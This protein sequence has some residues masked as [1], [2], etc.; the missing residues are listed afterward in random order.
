MK[1]ATYCEQSQSLEL[2]FGSGSVYRY[3]G[4]P[5]ETYQELL[6]AESKGK[7]FNQRIRNRFSFAELERPR[8]N[9]VR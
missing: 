8:A 5:V 2:E 9:T 3:H 4:V 1:A 6:R 7:Y